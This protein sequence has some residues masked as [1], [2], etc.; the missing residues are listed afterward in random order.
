MGYPIYQSV[1]KLKLRK[2]VEKVTSLSDEDFEGIFDLFEGVSI[3]KYDYIV[4]KNFSVPYDFW[5]VE[6]GVKAHVIDD[7]GKE[8]ILQ[9]AMENCWISDYEAYFKQ[10]PA[11]FNINCI[12][13]S[14]L[15]TLTLK[16]RQK[17]CRTFPE[18]GRFFN[19]NHHISYMDMQQRILS[20][21]P[22]SA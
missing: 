9:F 18:V 21:L 11:R 22:Q 5:I 10:K 1:S 19:M 17:L 6:G 8:H 4:Q 14:I 20:L 16:N 15:L 13:D 12:E 2:Q 7:D 3:E